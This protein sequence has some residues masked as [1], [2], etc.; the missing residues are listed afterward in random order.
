MKRLYAVALL[1][2]A[3]PAFGQIRGV[4]ASVTS[5]GP[6]RSSTPGVPASVTSLG[7]NGYGQ[8]Y[9]QVAPHRNR[10]FGN[11][12]YNTMCS[13]PGTLVSSAMGCTNPYFTNQNYGLPANAPAVNTRNRGRGHNNGGY[14]PVYV[15]YAVPVYAEEESAPPTD[16]R[17]IAE[18]EA[19]EPP[20]VTVF[21]HRARMAPTVSA[22]APVNEGRVYHPAPNQ[23]TAPVA[24]EH[25]APAI[26]LIY[27]DGHQR[28][29]QNYAIMGSYIY[30]I[31]SFVA[32]KIP[33][34]DLNLKAT[35]KAND[36][37]GVDFSLPAGIVP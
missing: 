22:A 28:E 37:R 1:A 7:P 29:V 16:T 10:D 17:A 36:D 19:D 18:D 14:Y 31:G 27:K 23:A 12:D 11:Y 33:L 32:Q 3:L 25:L 6:G 2:L 30:D 4:P 20:A 26:V 21:E 5:Q 34:S 35:L 13:T 24:E 9:S 8:R 15:P